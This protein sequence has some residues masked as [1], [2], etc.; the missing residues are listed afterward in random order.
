MARFLWRGTTALVF[1]L[2]AYWGFAASSN[3]IRLRNE[4]I[5]TSEK[6]QVRA[7]AKALQPQTG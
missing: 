1:L 7:T 5:A 3:L 6:S 4:Q 2:T